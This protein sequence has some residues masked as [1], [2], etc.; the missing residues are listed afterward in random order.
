MKKRIPHSVLA[1]ALLLVLCGSL[2]AQHFNTSM[3]T[4][5][6]SRVSFDTERGTLSGLLYRPKDLS[7]PRPAVVVTHGYLN[8]AE[9]Q[10]ANAIE[11]SRRG[12]VVLALDMYDHGHSKGND[13]N[14]GAFFKFWPDALYDAAAWMY[15]RDY[16]LKDEQGNGM[17]GVTGHS[18]GGFSSS[19]AIYKDEQAFAEKGYRMIAAGLSMGSDFQWSSYLGLTPEVAAQNGG[20]RTMGKLAGRYDEFFFNADDAPA[21]TVRKKSFVDTAAGKAWLE[22][23]EPAAD[24]WYTAADGGRRIIYQPCETHP[25]NHFSKR[26]TAHV[27]D[28]YMTA[29]QAHAH[30]LKAV[31]ADS[32]IWLWKEIF[33]CVALIGLLLLAVPLAMLVMKLPFFALAKTRLPAALPGAKTAGGKLGNRTALLVLILLPAMLFPTLMDKNLKSESMMLLFD[34][35]VIFA[36]AGLAALWLGRKDD[37][38][39]HWMAA[40]AVTLLGGVGLALLTSLPTYG[41]AAFWTA[42]SVNQIAFWTV[43]CAVITVIALGFIHAVSRK[44]AGAA[45]AHYGLV[46]K[47][48]T[49]LAAL[50][51]A[52]VTALG[53]YAV[54]FLA[55]ALFVTDFR[56]WVFAFKTFE[57]NVAPAMLRYAPTFLFY[58]LLSSA[59]IMVNTNTEAAQGIKG[60]LLA[61]ALNCGGIVIFLIR[62]Y[63][64]LFLTGVA[65]HPAQALSSILLFAMVPTLMFA[66]CFSRALYKRTGNVWTAAFLNAILVTVMTLAN[67]CV[68]FR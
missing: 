48:V 12:F 22:Q 68:Y 53:L 23:Q 25:W 1:L 50:C 61:M 65:A 49:V 15:S 37:K 62:Q 64:T 55:D 38:R 67:T 34:F 44:D 7:A 52:A 51:T 59:A 42:P 54:V 24:T 27:V 11:L 21:G 28:F 8:S 40:G 14:T 39:R 31:P 45:W 66:A 30:L 17:I 9:M 26:S 29:F 13:G 56:L 35:G 18:M 63:G 2:L 46:F 60:Y 36:L 3:Q 5:S 57:P 10:D 33:E 32:Q 6:V 58:Y 47:P 20:G 16:V 43:V 19:M 4:V 41:D